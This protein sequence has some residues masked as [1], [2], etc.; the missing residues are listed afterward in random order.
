MKNHSIFI[1]FSHVLGIEPS[2]VG[3]F[4]LRQMEQKQDAA[5]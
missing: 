5:V 1:K 3:A 4:L 2:E